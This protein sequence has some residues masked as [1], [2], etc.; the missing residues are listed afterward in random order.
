MGQ[1]ANGTR[2][3]I[4]AAAGRLFAEKGF[5]DTTVADICREAQANIAAVN[6]H[7]GG[8]ELLY[9][10][11][12]RHAHARSLARFPPDGGVP[13]DAPAAD[14]LR[15]RI[16][17]MLQR[18]LSDDGLEFRIMRHEMANPTGLL[19]QVLHDTLS[20]MREATRRILADL[21]ARPVDDHTLELCD[22]S[23]IG[24]VMHVLGR[25]HMRPPGTGRDERTGPPPFT[26]DMLDGMVEHFVQFALAGLAEVRGRVSERGERESQRK[27][28]T[29]NSG[30]NS[31]SNS[32]VRR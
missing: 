24:P 10:Q 11:A 15:G 9:G 30:R 14:R 17:G 1:G 25:R 27:S 12:W 23:V 3:R 20:P 7:F 18:A 6:Y 28:R 13:A 8:K 21:I 29:C 2:E 26:A 5:R 19:R 31:T 4:L 32:K 22:L 16:R